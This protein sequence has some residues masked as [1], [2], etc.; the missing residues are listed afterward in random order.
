MTFTMN[1]KHLVSGGHEGVQV[2]RVKDGERL[3]AM[4]VE[5]TVCSLAVS[6]DGR[7]IA[8]GSGLGDVWVWDGRT[9]EQV[10]VVEVLGGP[11]IYNVDFS[12]DL[13][14]LV[15]ANWWNQWMAC[16]ATIWDIAARTSVQKFEH[17][18]WVLVAKYS[19]QGNRITTASDGS[20]RVWDSDDGQLL[21][22]VKVALDPWRGLLWFDNHLFVK[23][24]DSKIKQI[25]AST[26]SIVAEWPVPYNSISCM[27]L[28][29]HGKFIACSTKDSITF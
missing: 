13:I 15:S 12:P 21:V 28:P 19:P 8:A 4:Q 9:Y 27:A 11:I 3:G 14:Q 24:K 29:Q 17:G 7:F 10:F 1:G 5:H 20:V 18:D 26:G 22:N 16:T 25:E 23:T 2:W 6:K